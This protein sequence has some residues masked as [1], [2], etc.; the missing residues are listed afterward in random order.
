[1]LISGL[2]TLRLSQWLIFD[3]DS[4][5]SFS[6]HLFVFPSKVLR[7]SQVQVLQLLIVSPSCQTACLIPIEEG[8]WQIKLIMGDQH[9]NYAVTKTYH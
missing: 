7:S 5:L 4:L 2:S 8:A 9:T 3:E 1:M 6:L